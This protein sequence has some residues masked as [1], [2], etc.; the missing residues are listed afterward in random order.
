MKT[1]L[2]Y[3]DEAQKKLGL[4]DSEMSKKLG[5]TD[6]RTLVSSWKNRG[7]APEDYYCILIAEILDIDPLEIIAAANFARS[8]DDERKAFWENFAKQ[9]V[10]TV[11]GVLLGLAVL[12]GGFSGAMTAEKTAAVVA[13]FCLLLASHNVRFCKDL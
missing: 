6:N 5:G 3:V 10:K 4:N 2:E 9:H 7:S 12:L 13:V 8:K 1:F 11:A